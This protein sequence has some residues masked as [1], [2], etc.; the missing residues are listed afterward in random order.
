MGRLNSGQA[1]KST[2]TQP[3]RNSLRAGLHVHP[4]APNHQAS[5]IHHPCATV[6]RSLPVMFN[7]LKRDMRRTALISASIIQVRPLQ[8]QRRVIR[9]VWTHPADLTCRQFAVL[10]GRH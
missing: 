2:S 4:Q 1:A 10:V 6:F 8:S 3:C 5:C 9:L 7:S